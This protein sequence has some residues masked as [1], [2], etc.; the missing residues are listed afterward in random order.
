MAIGSP[1]KRVKRKPGKSSA[2]V[3]TKSSRIVIVNGHFETPTTRADLREYIQFI[4]EFVQTVQAGRKAG[5]SVDEVGKA[6]TTP[7]KYPGYEAMPIPVRVRG[8]TD[9]IFKETN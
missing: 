2:N 6:W 3:F 5:K 4:R 7:A 1:L 8:N 9:L